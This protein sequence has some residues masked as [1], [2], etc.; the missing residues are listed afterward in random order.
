MEQSKSFS[1]AVNHMSKQIQELKA[2][3][4]D[5]VE[6][7]VF[8][9]NALVGQLNTVNDQI[10]NISVKGHT[11]NDLLDQRDVILKELSSLTET[12][13]SFDKWGRAEVTIDGTVVSG[14]EVEETLS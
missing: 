1:D 4:V 10:F 12:K 7:N 3:T 8:D 11:P 13:E 9:V 2:D 5:N 6:K 14:K